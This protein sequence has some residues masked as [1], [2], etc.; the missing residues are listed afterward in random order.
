L[1]EERLVP[2]TLT[3]STA[4]GVRSILET[5]FLY[6][7]IGIAI[8]DRSTRFVRSN[9]RLQRM[10]GYTAAEMRTLHA[11]D[12]T[13]PDDLP[14]IMALRERVFEGRLNDFVLDKRCIR[15]NRSLFWGRNNVAA[16]PT[17]NDGHL[18]RYL[19]ELVEDISE[20]KA[21]EATLR[22]SSAQLRALTRRLVSLQE[23]E[24]RHLAAELHDQI[25]QALAV[26]GLKLTV[27]E[28]QL[29]PG[30]KACAQALHD[31]E[32]MLEEA[33]QA[34]RSVISQL[35]PAV[36]D[37]YGLAAALRALAEQASRRH[38]F[39]V[40]VDA[41]EDLPRAPAEVEATFFRIAQEALTNVARHAG[42]NAVHI[43][44]KAR[45]KGV[46]MFMMD[47]GRGF[48]SAE[49]KRPQKRASW[50]LLMMRERA[51]A[52]GVR[53]HIHSAPGKGTR[54]LVSWRPPA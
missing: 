42:A 31:A 49:L 9:V 48:D 50:G 53:L 43:L 38:G 10:L 20:I 45:G 15:K 30:Q 32:S 44:L 52:A 14:P 1:G 8:T 47:N 27:A 25:G 13:H 19:L 2:R 54:V 16:V 6:A 18:P 21:A 22:A 46:V 37:D 24:R 34:A 3:S 4:G 12:V 23:D 7:P 29:A 17:H 41:A 5:L 33:G 40:H 35:R 11:A 36:L 28:A 39:S 51:E 26:I